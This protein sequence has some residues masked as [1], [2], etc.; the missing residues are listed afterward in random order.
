[1]YVPS[2]FAETRLDVLHKFIREHSFASI[3]S[4]AVAD[5]PAVSHVPTVLLPER[6]EFG[7]LQF[8]LAKPN[9]QCEALARREPAVAVFHGPHAYVSPTWYVSTVVVPTWNY[10]V[11]HAHGT[12]RTLD[13]AELAEHLRMLAASYEGPEPDG[14]STDRLPA[15]TFAKLRRA[16][17]GFEFEITRVEGKW[18]LGQNRHE[19]DVRGAIRGLSEKGDAES[20]RVAE[21]MKAAAAA[22][23]RG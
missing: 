15:E 1:M 17:V 19:E 12:P 7:T 22:R 8:H 5:G 23:T 2:E 18:K 13:D 14:W 20:L 10:A 16:I 6:G 4:G 3:V 9:E 21:M 11:V